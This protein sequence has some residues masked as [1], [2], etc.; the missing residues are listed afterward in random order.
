MA[1]VII[2]L[3]PGANQGV[4]EAIDGVNKIKQAD[5]SAEAQIKK[6]TQAFEEQGN[7]IKATRSELE[8]F[9]KATKDI[10]KVIVGGAAKEIENLKKQFQSGELVINQYATAVALAKKELSALPQSS[11]AYQRLS[12]E[13]EA[14][15]VAQEFVTGSAKTL[16]AEFAQVRNAIGALIE[17]GLDNTK[18]F[19]DLT[20]R[21]GELSDTIGDIAER[22]K[23]LGSDTKNIDAAVEFVGGLAGA[24]SIAQ[25]AI[26]LFGEENEELQQ[27]LLKVNAAMALA[28]G[29]QQISTLLKGQGA[30]IQVTENAL[31]LA[32]VASTN[33]QSAAE[34]RFIVVRGAAIATQRVLNSVMAASPAGVLLLAI[35]ALAAALVIFT[36]NSDDA[37]EA[38]N[39]LNQEV[40][41]GIEL[42]N[43][44]Q[45]AIADA[46]DVIVARLEANGAKE[47]EIRKAQINNLKSQIAEQKKAYD[48]ANANYARANEE[49]E[50]KVK[51]GIDI[52]NEERE[53][54]LKAYDLANKA[55]ETFFGLQ[56]ALEI[57]E[58]NSIRDANKEK[59]EADKKAA[60]DRKKAK[61]KEVEATK[62]FLDD[63][64]AANEIA[65][66]ESQDGLRKIVQD[67]LSKFREFEAQVQVILARTRRAMAE[68]GTT[69][70]Q[71]VL[72]E[73]KAND[74]I[75]RAREQ[76]FVDLTRIENK[77]TAAY[78]QDLKIKVLKSAEFNQKRLE[79][80]QAAAQ[81]RLQI[82]QD[83]A[84]KRQLLQEQLLSITSQITGTLLEISR[85]ANEAELNSL[86]ERL[87]QGLISQEQYEIQ[88]RQIKRRQ[89][90][91][92]KSLALFQA[93]IDG[94]AAI[95]KA[96]RD[97]GI[98]LG[99]FT[100]A[101]VAAQIAA[102][103]TKPIP[104]FKDG[105]K[106]APSGPALVAEAGPE[107]WFH[108]GKLQYLDS[109]QIVDLNR[110]DKIIPAMDTAKIL[111]NWN[112]PVVS[113]SSFDSPY[114]QSAEFSFDYVKMAKAFAKEMGNLPLN[115]FTFD[116]NGYAKRT[117]KAEELKRKR[118][119]RYGF[120]RY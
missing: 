70:N 8:K 100:S 54:R 32:G 79:Q 18:V 1:N 99:I 85:N 82:L 97:G 78:A 98:P 96:F 91:Q 112:V 25:S 11:A 102:I 55:G 47:A 10:P 38:Q 86:Q 15:G 90:V 63:Q 93:T 83:E 73:L 109:P 33:L 31:R 87:D 118:Q 3:V 64:I 95:V 94:A 105:T 48:Q 111:S 4:T 24:Y 61:E 5:L 89:A 53:A 29:L 13:I 68:P 57:A 12:K 50:R 17:A 9:A 27:V 36:N 71:R 56:R 20:A 19:Q 115:E 81:A 16:R 59:L 114:G 22:T 69:K 37:A 39:K 101:L 44:Y 40:E 84:L 113:A 67:G 104:A 62:K 49:F 110:G 80:E 119:N 117:M 66:L 74:E 77:N 34:S 41:N 108:N 46:G 30:A 28:N 42:A 116:E 23:A 60:E 92:D 35:T 72:L 120:G 2:D 58:L 76:L 52:S 14:A 21:G 88:V 7:E 106:N 103:A 75:R 51:D 43:L 45:A 107:L 6:S 26:A 65:L